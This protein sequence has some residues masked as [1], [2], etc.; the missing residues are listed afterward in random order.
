[1]EKIK[2]MGTWEES[3]IKIGI[4]VYNPEQELPKED[5]ARRSLL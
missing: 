5:E 2:E 3:S 4:F 1:M